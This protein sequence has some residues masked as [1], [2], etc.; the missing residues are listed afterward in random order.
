M[1]DASKAEATAQALKAAGKT[2]KGEGNPTK[3]K[4]DREEKMHRM[5][6]KK[7][8]RMMAREAEER[9]QKE[10]KEELKAQGPLENRLHLGVGG[11]ML[12]CMCCSCS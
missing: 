4:K 11:V 10:L 1:V 6:R 3:T 2:E 5:T 12:S 8:R 7:R 9:E